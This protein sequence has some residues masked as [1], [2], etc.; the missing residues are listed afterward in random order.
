V[1]GHA[2][3]AAAE[4][5]GERIR[6]RL[7]SVPPSAAPADRRFHLVAN[8]AFPVGLL[9]HLAFV[10]IFGAVGAAPLA[11]LNVAS[12]AAWALAIRLQT[13]GRILGSISLVLVEVILHAIACVAVIGWA[14]GF[15]YYVLTL[16]TTAFFTPTRFALKVLPVALAALVFAAMHYAFAH[17]A[18]YVALAPWVLD[19]MYYGN[20]LSVFFV[21][22][23]SS[24]AFERAATAAEATLVEER[25]RSDELAALL[26]AMFGRYLAPEVMR[27]MIE[28]PA[29]LELGGQKRRVTL[30]MSDLRGFTALAERLAPEQVVRLLNTY[31]EVMV[32]VIT[33]YHGTV[34]E[35]I[36]DAL[37]VLFGAPQDMPDRAE[38][39]VACAIEMQ[40]A[41]AEVNARNRAAGLPELQMG[42]GLNDAEVVVGNIGTERRSKYAAVGSG[43]NLASRIES[44]SVGGEVLVSDS[45]RAALGDALRIDGQREVRPKGAEAPL[46]I[47]QVGGIGGSYNVALE[48]AD[49]GWITPPVH[50]PLRYSVLSDKAADAE[51]QPAAL[52]RL[53]RNS[54]E[55]V[56]AGELAAMADL[57]MNLAAAEGPLAGRDFYGKVVRA[58][59]TAGERAVVRFTSVPPEVDAYFQALRRCAQPPEPP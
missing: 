23:V 48:L 59:S 4:S 55:I 28:D 38:R 36:G 43:V 29:A 42:I 6:R 20:V 57:R 16:A 3:P 51:R 18:P 26:Q 8:I 50:V 39:A 14:A 49:S 46:R 58:A 13:R 17:A 41:M 22:A 27:S 53:A 24:A 7:A 25:T 30:L 34:N 32:E 37:L 1:T 21:V 11:L 35:I 5:L 2:N 9:W 56:A 44:Y 54:A 33:K 15:Q 31:L 12:V 40:N 52:V 47:C 45:V 10:F 19:A